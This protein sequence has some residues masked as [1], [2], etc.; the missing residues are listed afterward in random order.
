MLTNI[1][2]IFIAETK[3]I[4]YQVSG[5]ILCQN[6]VTVCMVIM[7]ASHIMR[8]CNPLHI[9]GTNLNYKTIQATSLLVL[10]KSQKN[11]LKKSI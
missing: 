8:E 1:E 7:T 2:L 4:T 11:S 5:L 3:T 10:K 9:H 6:M